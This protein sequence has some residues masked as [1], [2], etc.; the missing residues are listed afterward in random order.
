MTDNDCSE[1]VIDIFLT[2]VPDEDGFYRVVGVYFSKE[3][4]VMQGKEVAQNYFRIERWM[5][6][7]SQ[8]VEILEYRKNGWREQ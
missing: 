4:A 6:E 3:A 7:T 1:P 8:P 2:L 5:L